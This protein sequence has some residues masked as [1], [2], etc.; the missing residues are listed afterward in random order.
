MSGPAG[1]GAAGE[2]VTAKVYRCVVLEL[3]SRPGADNAWSDQGGVGD[4]E[5]EQVHRRVATDRQLQPIVAQR[6]QRKDQRQQKEIGHRQ[7]AIGVEV[8]QSENQPHRCGDQA[9]ASRDPPERLRQVA[10]KQE[11]LA[12]GLQRNQEYRQSEKRQRRRD[13]EAPRPS[14]KLMHEGELSREDRKLDAAA[15]GEASPVEAE[16]WR[17]Q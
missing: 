9:T 4:P 10:A 11:F 17:D 6:D 14:S 12:R 7:P 3:K 16:I 1:G 5:R 2:E 15:D 13:R 8:Q